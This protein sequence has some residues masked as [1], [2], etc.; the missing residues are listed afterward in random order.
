VSQT[1]TQLANTHPRATDKHDAALTVFSHRGPSWGRPPC[2]AGKGVGGRG[3]CHLTKLARWTRGWGVV[4]NYPPRRVCVCVWV[5][6]CV[7]VCEGRR[8]G[9]REGRE[10]FAS[11]K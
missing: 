5:C 6:V 7:C 11:Q 2:T 1:G 8:E 10:V 3:G 9:G 4:R